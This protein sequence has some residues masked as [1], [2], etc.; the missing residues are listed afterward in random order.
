MIKFGWKKFLMEKWQIQHFTR[1]FNMT[2]ISL[3]R[4]LYIEHANKSERKMN[5]MLITGHTNKKTADIY[6]YE[7]ILEEK[8]NFHRSLIIPINQ[9]ELD[10]IKSYNLINKVTP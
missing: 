9:E 7:L 6:L 5:P 1:Y 8:K 2:S 3:R 4:G 10:S